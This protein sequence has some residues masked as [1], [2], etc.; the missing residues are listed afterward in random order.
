MDREI[1]DDLA[2][3]LGITPKEVRERIR[4]ACN[5]ER[6]FYAGLKHGHF[7][8]NKRLGILKDENQ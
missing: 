2:K 3:I 5:R 4:D 7:K 1:F 8:R 6:P